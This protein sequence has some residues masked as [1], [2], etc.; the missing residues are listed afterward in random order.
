M[1]GKICA[2]CSKK[3]NNIDAIISLCRC[4]KIF[5][6]SHRIDHSCEYDYKKEYK[7]CNDLVKVVAEKVSK[8]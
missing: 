3:I 7:K 5:C 4:G 8:I 2:F 6:K 1:S